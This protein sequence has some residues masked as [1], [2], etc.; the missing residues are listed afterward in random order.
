MLTAA[1]PFLTQ[2]AQET[3]MY[4]LVVAARASSPA[5]RF[6][7]AFV[8]PVP[9]SARRAGGAAGFA[10]TLATLLYTHNWALF[11]G[12]ACGLAWSG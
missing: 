1:N 11:F 8:L 5:R 9:A 4:A 2:Y 12:V 7:R 10:L 6:V 3:R